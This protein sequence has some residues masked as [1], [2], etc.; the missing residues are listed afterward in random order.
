M[1][2]MTIQTQRRELYINYASNAASIITTDMSNK[3]QPYC[4]TSLIN[5]WHIEEL[6][7]LFKIEV[8]DFNMH[9]TNIH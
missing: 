3:Q 4:L 6:F 8:Y 5:H 1:V 2:F 9:M 7:N